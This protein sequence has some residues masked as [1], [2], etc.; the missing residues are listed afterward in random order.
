MLENLPLGALK[1]DVGI[2]LEQQRRFPLDTALALLGRFRAAKFHHFKRGKKGISYISPIK[3]RRRVSGESFSPSIEAL[4]SFVEKYPLTEKGSLAEKHL[5][6]SADKKD[7][8]KNSDA[9]RTLARDL[10]WL[11]AEGYAT[12]YSDGRLE[13]RSQIAA[14]EGK[15]KE[16]E[17]D[18]EADQEADDESKNPQVDKNRGDPE[19]ASTDSD[20]EGLR[21]S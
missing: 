15:S 2:T 13:I 18:I 14:N 20:S 5:G 17:I 19:D 11:I 10:R 8:P 7:D 4:I 12:E 16:N 1:D 21:Q 6:I 3:R 9:I